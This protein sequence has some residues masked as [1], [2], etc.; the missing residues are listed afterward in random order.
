M[1]KKKGGFSTFTLNDYLITEE[2][3]VVNVRWGGRKVKP[4]PNGKGY[5]RVHIA[6]RM[7]FVHR[8][9][10]EKYIPNPDNLPQI[11]HKDGDK[12]NNRADNLEWVSNLENRQHAVKER[13]HVH[14]ERCPWAKLKQADVDYIRQHT[15][16]S[17]RRIAKKFGVSD[18]LI[19]AIRRREAWK[20]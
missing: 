15:E 12:T 19:R 11:N 16:M 6:G 2:G 8:L 5:M 7:Y 1:E 10:A 20:D 3:E 17:S 13:L 9:V 14:G 4:Q 18:S